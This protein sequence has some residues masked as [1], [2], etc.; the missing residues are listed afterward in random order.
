MSLSDL[1]ERATLLHSHCPDQS[2]TQKR[3]ETW[4]GAAPSPL[5]QDEDPKSMLQRSKITEI[6]V[7]HVLPRVEE[8]EYAREFAQMSPDIDDEQREV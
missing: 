4:L 3:I 8:W 2:I 7:L 5:S 1:G 6:Y